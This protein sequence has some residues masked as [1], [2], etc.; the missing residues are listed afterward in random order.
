[1]SILNKTVKVNWGPNKG[2]FGVVTYEAVGYVFVRFSDL[3][4]YWVNTNKIDG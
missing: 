4:G 1:M 2:L 3:S